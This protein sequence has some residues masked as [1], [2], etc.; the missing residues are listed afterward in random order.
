MRHYSENHFAAL[1]V[2]VNWET[3]SHPSQSVMRKHERAIWFV[4]RMKQ[5]HFFFF[6]GDKSM[7]KSSVTS[8]AE[9][10]WRRC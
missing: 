5:V 4:D 10:L 2:D 9:L 1:L 7:T 3:G 6:N 8:A